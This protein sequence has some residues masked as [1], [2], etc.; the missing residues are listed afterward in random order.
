MTVA[1]R[2]WI[3][4]LL[5][6]LLA[7]AGYSMWRV[8]RNYNAATTVSTSGP[9]SIEPATNAGLEWEDFEFTER[10]GQRINLA[11]MRGKVWV[12]SFFFA[13]CPGNCL[14]M[15]QA[16]AQLEH[17]FAPQGVRFVSVTVDPKNDTPER[18]A[19]YANTL[20]A[21]PDNWLFLTGDF[22]RVQ[23]LGQDKLKVTVVPK[24]HTDRLILVDRS[25]DVRGTF[26]SMDPVQLR[27][28]KKKLVTLLSEE[29][30]AASTSP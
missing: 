28:F 25:G 20:E 1:V 3:T 9:T 21:D 4:L 26:R 7:Y 18:L 6:L 24:D 22:S 16:I 19:S 15:N 8:A 13:S 27:A 12:V 10:S 14:K 11:S 29:D 2:L 23:A 5:G 30:A 17:E